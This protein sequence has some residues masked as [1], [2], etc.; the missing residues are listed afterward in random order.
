MKAGVRQIQ[1]S[2]KAYGKPVVEPDCLDNYKFMMNDFVK[3]GS[4]KIEEL[5]KRLQELETFTANLATDLGES[6]RDENGVLDLTFLKTLNKF[7]KDV[8]VIFSMVGKLCFYV[9]LEGG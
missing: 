7:R 1:N 8:K 5:S 9:F 6:P 3:F 4:E 2:L